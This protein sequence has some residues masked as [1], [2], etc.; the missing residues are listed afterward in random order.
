MSFNL[1]GV[2]YYQ[3]TEACRL[4][5]ISRNTFLRWVKEGTFI[6]VTNRD[7]RGWRLF[8]ENDLKALK[9]EVN[10]INKI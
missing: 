9:S 7:R 2:T 3:T 1:G 5:G 4:A 6:D 10:R 8:T